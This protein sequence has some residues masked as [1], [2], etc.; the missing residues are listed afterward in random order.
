MPVDPIGA[1]M[2]VAVG[3]LFMLGMTILYR[4]LWA[5]NH[6]CYQT[7]YFRRRFERSHALRMILRFSLWTEQNGLIQYIIRLI[8]FGI[9]VAMFLFGLSELNIL[10]I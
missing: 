4:P 5:L 3:V 2:F 1:W 9:G 8:Y 7:N 10:K 6:R